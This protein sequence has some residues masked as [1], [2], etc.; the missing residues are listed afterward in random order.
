MQIR[1][2]LLGTRSDCVAEH[3]YVLC[4][5]TDV[6]KGFSLAGCAPCDQGHISC[7]MLSSL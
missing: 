1:H 7:D 5:C 6:K 3:P 4:N 2:Q